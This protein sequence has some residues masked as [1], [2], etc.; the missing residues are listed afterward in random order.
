MKLKKLNARGF[1]HDILL[2]L[3]VVIFAIAGVAYLVATRAST[4]TST[5]TTYAGSQNTPASLQ[6][7][8]LG[9][10]LYALKTFNNKIYAGYGDYGANT[11]PIAI[12]PFAFDQATNTFTFASTAENSPC[13]QNIG[14]SGQPLNTDITETWR[15]VGSANP[16]DPNTGKPATGN[17]QY[18]FGNCDQTEAIGLYRVLNG[19]LYAPSSD[20]RGSDSTDYAVGTASTNGSVSWQQFG[21]KLPAIYEGVGMTHAFDMNSI[22]G[23]NDLWMVGSQGNDAVAY[24]SLN[25]GAT[26]AKMADVAPTATYPGGYD[27]FYAAGVYNGKVYFQAVMIDSNNN[28]VGSEPKSHVCDDTACT[29]GPSLTLNNMWHPEAFAGKMIYQTWPG[30]DNPS[31]T[32]LVS[33]DGSNTQT[34]TATPGGV[35]DYTIDGNTLY[36]L[37]G[38]GTI[39]SATLDSTTGLL[40]WYVQSTAPT[41][42][43]SIA[44]MNNVIYV[45]TTDSKIYKAPVN[46]A[47]SSISGSTSGGGKT[48][49]GGKGGH[50]PKQ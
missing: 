26:W 41:T 20:P 9:K 29:A 49:G 44:V 12:T 47:P 18:D 17:I 33:F 50:V 39:Y 1:S 40:N 11:G 37:S 10:T 13:V 34:I 32:Y 36:A 24:H 31:A 2:V 48:H 5:F 25:G 4:S 15:Y 19:K 3:F 45:G 8:A 6:P 42:A 27:R 14:S 21:T 35:Y 23:T 43:R 7:T 46:T 22:P 30:V 16:I 38:F 28:E